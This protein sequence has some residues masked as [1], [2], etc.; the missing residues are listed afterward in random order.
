MRKRIA[1]GIVAVAL[2]ATACSSSSSS[3]PSPTSPSPTVVSASAYAAS[4][5]TAA[6]TYETT[7]KQEAAGF[8]ANTTDLAVLKQ[9]FLDLLNGIL[10][11]TQTLSSAVDAAGVPDTPNGQQDVDSIHTQ[12]GAL[13]QDIQDLIDQAETLS[14]T[15]PAAFASAFQPMIQKFQTA[16]Q[17]F[18]QN[19]EKPNDPQLA[20][21]FSQTPECASLVSATPS[22]STSPSA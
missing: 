1:T 16:I 17:E 6:N 20:V 8:N 7:V 2:F 5:C 13:Q 21:A 9:S 14:T 15:D 4:V 10:Q 3:T 12:L 22:T 18:G 19:F 11:S